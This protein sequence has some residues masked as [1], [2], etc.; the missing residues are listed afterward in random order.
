MA[1][2]AGVHIDDYEVFI[3]LVNKQLIINANCL[4]YPCRYKVCVTGFAKILDKGMIISIYHIAEKFGREKFGEF[5]LFKHL[6]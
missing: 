3:L 4:H 1:H 2:L 6:A 5:N